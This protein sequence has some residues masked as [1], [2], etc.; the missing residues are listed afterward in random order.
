MHMLLLLLA[1]V[2]PTAFGLRYDGALSQGTEMSAVGM[3]APSATSPS[4]A[5]NQAEGLEVAVPISHRTS[6]SVAGGT[7]PMALGEG[8]VAV[9]G[10]LRL[11]TT[12]AEGPRGSVGVTGGVGGYFLGGPGGGA[13]IGAA[14]SRDVGHDLR[15]FVGL[16]ANPV[17]LSRSPAAL[18]VLGGAGLSWTPRLS[19][20]VRLLARAE[21]DAYGGLGTVYTLEGGTITLSEPL[22]LDPRNTLM[23]AATLQLGVIVGHALPTAAERARARE[24]EKRSTIADW[25]AVHR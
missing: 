18:W 22:G 21:A 14:A 4:S 5:A 10:E 3:I 9:G 2:P 1:C 23:G 7:L 11:A 6:V 8:T 13:S 19:P 17:L 16:I 12:V 20:T 15:P 24:G 25:D